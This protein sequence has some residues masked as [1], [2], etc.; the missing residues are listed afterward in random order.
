MVNRILK[1][2][3]LVTGA[4]R[5]IGRAAALRLAGEG[6][7]LALHYNASDAAVKE[8]AEAIKALGVDV[9]IFKADLAHIAESETLIDRVTE[10]FP[11]LNAVIN[12]ASVF[13]KDDIFSFSEADWHKH[14]N[15]NCLSPVALIRRLGAYLA[16]R[17]QTGCAINV[18]DQR[19][20]RPN[21]NFFTYTASK[22][23]IYDLTKTTA[24][25]LAPH[26]RVNGILPGPV[27]A[28]TRQSEAEF[29]KQV[30]LT[31]LGKRVSLEE[32]TA[33]MSLILQS[34]AMTGAFITLDS[35]Q[36]ADWRTPDFLHVKE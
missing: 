10:R 27:L 7:D 11:G 23:L 34:P 22:M 17:E 28:N 1:Q 25:A 6:C 3:V 21:P 2:T 4:G 36:S 14:M 33:A 29:E 12:N 8:T 20:L 26:M 35:G 24:A 19:V 5:R 31:P 30:A 9:D 32:I 16:K 15:V 13:E 18:I